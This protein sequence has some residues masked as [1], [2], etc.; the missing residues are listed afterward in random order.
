[1]SVPVLGRPPR[2]AARTLVIAPRMPA[3][4]KHHT[5][6]PFTS[7]GDVVAECQTCAD[8]GGK[9]YCCSGTRAEVKRA[10]DEHHRTFHPHET[11]VVLLNAPR[12]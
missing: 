7:Q 1:M 9:V 2:L 11:G 8:L 10:M 5:G 12:Q 4:P 6:N 3:P